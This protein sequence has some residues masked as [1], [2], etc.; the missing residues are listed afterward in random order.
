MVLGPV[1]ALL[2]AAAAALEA[3]PGSASAAAEATTYAAAWRTAED[4]AWQARSRAVASASR[5]ADA[6][7][8]ADADA[9]D[10]P[11]LRAE[12]ATHSATTAPLQEHEV[13][14]LLR[15][16]LPPGS[17]LAIGN[18][19]P[20]RDL[21]HDLPPD[22]QALTLLHQRGAAGI[23][24]GV[25]GAAGARS[26]LAA[27]MAL[28]L[29]DVALLH[30]T[31]GLAAA[32][33]VRGPLAIVVVHNDGGRIFERLPLGRDASLAGACEQLFVVP[34]GHGF[35][36]LAATWGL[37]FARVDTAA[38]LA[39]ALA[40]ALAAERPILIEARVAPGGSARRAGLLAAMAQAADAAMGA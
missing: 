16:A 3:Q 7:A 29:G 17:W 26:V 11:G 8:D 23:D 19:S 27:P 38:A 30:D 2:H 13:A 1:A 36:G 34:H 4:A 5:L 14:P 39:Q 6:D 31:G 32:A 20:V 15:A 21:D 10:D 22:G 9:H 28:L 37:A 25:A 12:A 40:R 35:D 33:A 24:G 18:S